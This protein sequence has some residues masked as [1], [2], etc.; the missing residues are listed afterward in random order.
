MEY[1][2][3][4][5]EL[6]NRTSRGLSNELVGR[7]GFVEVKEGTLAIIYPLPSQGIA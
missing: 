1:E 6:S 4:D 2:A 3:I 7:P 5:F